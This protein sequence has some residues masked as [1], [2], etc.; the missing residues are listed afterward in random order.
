[1]PADKDRESVAEEMSSL[2]AALRHMHLLDADEQPR[3]ELLAGGVSSRIAR[4]ET[5]R[6]VLC[7]KQAL[8]RLRVQADW[9]APVERNATEVAWLRVVAKIAPSAVPRV[10]AEDGAS[11]AFAMEYLDPARHP[12]WKEALRDGRVESDFAARLGALVGKVHAAS[13][14]NGELAQAFAHDTEFDAIRLEPYLTATA[15]A[16]PTV[17]LRLLELRARTAATRRTLV[18]GDVS[19][20][21]I[22]VGPHGPVL[23]DAECAWYG[24]PAFDVAFCLNHLLLKCAWRPTHAR[25]FMQSFAALATAYFA[26]VQWESTHELEARIA[27]LLPGLLLAR[28]RGKSPIDYLADLHAPER[29]RGFAIDMLQH[30]V[31]T[32]DEIASAWALERKIR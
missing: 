3:M 11:H 10:V 1:M 27:S 5:R 22:L 29:I 28:L 15:R 2:L 13:A 16:E 17:A 30:P 12:V 31:R 9:R 8:P 24:D 6:G 26:Q 32:I 19:P 20:K 14:H 18:H 25:A 21:N 4:V 7:V 23:L